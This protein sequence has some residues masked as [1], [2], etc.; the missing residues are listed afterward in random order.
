MV[1]KLE[2]KLNLFVP[3]PS[4]N[5][6][7]FNES[8]VLIVD[9]IA[10]KDVNSDAVRERILAK[11]PDLSNSISGFMPTKKE[12]DANGEEMKDIEII[13]INGIGK[14]DSKTISLNR[15]LAYDKNNTFDNVH[16]FDGEK[17]ILSIS[18]ITFDKNSKTVIFE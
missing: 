8:F 10:L 4:T 7:S 14:K 15:L 3:A 18:K 9:S 6:E 16:M 12:L 2:K 5:F 11:R 1:I 17:W 13:G